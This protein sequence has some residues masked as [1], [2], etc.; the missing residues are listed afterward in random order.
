MDLGPRFATCRL[1]VS[2]GHLSLVSLM[3]LPIVRIMRSTAFSGSRAQDDSSSSVRDPDTHPPALEA[4]GREG[5]LRQGRGG[6]R[7]E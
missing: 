2:G 5:V 4:R 6:E 1:C 7:K 3:P